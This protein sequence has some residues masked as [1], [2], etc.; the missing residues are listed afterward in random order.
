VRAAR[1]PLAKVGLSEPRRR[2]DREAIRVLLATRAHA[3]N[4]EYLEKLISSASDGSVTVETAAEG[5]HF[6]IVKGGGEGFLPGRYRRID[7]SD[8]T[9]KDKRFDDNDLIAVFDEKGKL[10]G[11]ILV[12]R[13]FIGRG[14]IT[15]KTANKV[16]NAWDRGA[17]SLNQNENFDIRYLGLN[18]Y[19]SLGDYR[20]GHG[21][22]DGRTWRCWLSLRAKYNLKS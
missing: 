17:V 19:D 13:P 7:A 6:F 10:I 2:G 1:Q 16:D 18:I 5:L 4:E 12:Q 3:V 21:R 22:I 15:E 14:E 9:R 11:S 8:V 20:S